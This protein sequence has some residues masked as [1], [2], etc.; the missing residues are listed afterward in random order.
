MYNIATKFMTLKY[1]LGSLTFISVFQGWSQERTEDIKYAN[2]EL[3]YKFNDFCLGGRISNISLSIY[4]NEIGDT[5]CFWFN[6]TT[7]DGEQYYL[8]NPKAKK[9][10]YLFDRIKVAGQLS[11]ETREVV[12]PKKLGLFDLKVTDDCKT[13][14]FRFKSGKY[15]YDRTSGKLKVLPKDE[16]KSEEDEVIYSYMTLSPDKR[17]ILYAKNHNLYVKG[18]K[19]L[20]MDTTEVQ[21][22]TDGEKY[23]SYA[24]AEE[25]DEE[26]EVSSNVR[27][28]PDS[29]H[30][31]IVREDER[32]LRDFWVINSLSEKPS[33]ESYKY[34]FPGDKHVTQFVMTIIDVQERTARKVEVDKW[35][36]QYLMPFHVTPDSKYIFFERTKRTW[37]EVD[38]C[39]VNTSTLEVKEVIHEV[40]KPYRDVHARSVEILNNGNDILFRSERT[41]WAHYYHYDGDG[42]LKNAVS[43]GNWVSGHIV[44]ADTLKRTIYF[45]VYG[46]D[47]AINPY[48]Y[49]LYKANID[50]KGIK[51]LSGENAQ[52]NVTFLK[53]RRYYIDTFSRIDMEPR[54]LLKDNE[55]RTIMELAKPDLSQVYAEG[56]KM[57]EQFVVKAADQSTDLYGV[58]WKPSDFDPKKKYPIISVVYPGPYFGFVPTSFTLDNSYCTRMAQ[59][60]FIV[61]TVGHRG[62]S[63]MRGKVYHRFGYGNMRDYPL[64]D[65]KYA[66]EQLAKRYSYIDIDKVGIYG[67]SGGGFMAAA[68]ICTYPDFYKAAVSCSGNHDNNIFNRGW[69]ECYNGVREVEKVVKDSLNNETKEYEY[70]FSVKSNAELAK[71]LKGHL[72]LVTGDQDK[73]VNPAHTYRMA[74]ALIEEGKNFEMLVIPGAGHGYGAADSY[75]AQKMYRFFAKYLLGDTRADYWGDM[76][77]IK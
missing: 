68:A 21:L 29:R 55:G 52:H 9:K 4:P 65:D 34:E 2:Y 57:P 76:N 67:H 72:L 16:R 33:L 28:C 8:V 42:N 74:Q 7:S 6:F 26:G 38:V 23:F 47:P 3:A 66:I 19:A 61:I 12:N 13:V 44:A 37:D 63:P 22:T 43:S 10:E 30:A 45:Y 48:Y 73:N 54:I 77:R 49:K 56:W 46:D 40:D 60:G 14:T 18:N 11:E 75:F 20:G 64:A 69:G 1:L 50:G 17:Y 41:G 32:K 39:K 53:S 27:W 51:L 62:D 24:K 5:D 58:M 35:N 70:K 31:Y 36:D 59:L 15:S 25:A 71:N